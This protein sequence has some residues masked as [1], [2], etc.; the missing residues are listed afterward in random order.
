LSVSG[1]GRARH[2]LSGATSKWKKYTY[3]EIEA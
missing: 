1:F 3:S 2:R